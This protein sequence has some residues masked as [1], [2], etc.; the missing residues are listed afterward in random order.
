MNNAP[1]ISFNP[2]SYINFSAFTP[3]KVQSLY[4]Q[5][6]QNFPA[7]VQPFVSIIFA[8]LIIYTIYRII[9]QDFIFIIALAIL[10]PTSIPVMK[11]IWFGLV[12]F[13]KFLFSL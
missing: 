3:E 1:S 10:V 12:D 9:K 5:F 7:A 6:L 2:L 8:I 13:I 11:S 4:L